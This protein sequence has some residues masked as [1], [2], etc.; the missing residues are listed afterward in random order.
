MNL[1]YE[2]AYN[3]LESI[4]ERLESKNNKTQSE[5]EELHLKKKGD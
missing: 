2:E 3:K 1:T 5:I 4:L